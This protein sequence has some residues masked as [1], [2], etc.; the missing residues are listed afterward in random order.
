MQSS[1]AHP[2]SPQLC[3]S[4]GNSLY[5]SLPTPHPL[6][7]TLRKTHC[8]L[9]SRP[10]NCEPPREAADSR[11]SCTKQRRLCARTA[12]FTGLDRG[13]EPA[14]VRAGPVRGAQAGARR[15]RPPAPCR[16]PPAPAGPWPA[17]V[18]IFSGRGRCWRG[19]RPTW[20]RRRDRLGPRQPPR[21]GP[22]PAGENGG[23]VHPPARWRWR[24]EAPGSCVGLRQSPV[25]SHT[26]TPSIVWGMFSGCK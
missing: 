7:C 8:T 26:Y 10:H 9:H 20:H 11:P 25:T 17:A 5:C 1:T 6:K 23:S 18:A 3:T 15:M 24:R 14:R 22:Q 13:L 16:V 19:A 12:L 21:R 2:R 4:E